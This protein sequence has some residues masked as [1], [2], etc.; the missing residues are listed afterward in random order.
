MWRR[1]WSG[2][3]AM[4]R[5]LVAGLVALLSVGWLVPM[6]FG[7]ALYFDFWHAEGWPLLLGRQPMNSLDFLATARACFACGFAWLGVVLAF[8]AFVGM[9]AWMDRKRG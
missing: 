8:W 6:W 3:L 9:T 7:V 1:S 5:N 4:K 2:D